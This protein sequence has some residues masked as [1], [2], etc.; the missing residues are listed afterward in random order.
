M[1]VKG[2]F[3]AVGLASP[4]YFAAATY[5]FFYWLDR[6]A[7]AQANRAISGWL[8]GQS[9]ARIDIQHAILARY[10]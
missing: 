6:N 5:G 7:S 2:F 8:K 3:D 10:V 1:G 9:Y 4:F